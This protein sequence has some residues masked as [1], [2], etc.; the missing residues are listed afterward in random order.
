MALE[1][2]NEGLSSNKLPPIIVCDQLE[3]T[4]GC[5]SRSK[6]SLNLSA[7]YENMGGDHFTIK[8]DLGKHT[9]DIYEQESMSPEDSTDKTL[10]SATYQAEQN[11][12]ILKKACIDIPG[13]NDIM[14]GP[15]FRRAYSVLQHNPPSIKK[16]LAVPERQLRLPGIFCSNQVS[17]TCLR[18]DS[19]TSF[20]KKLPLNNICSNVGVGELSQ[21]QSITSSYR[22]TISQRQPLETFSRGLS[23][24]KNR[25]KSLQDVKGF[26]KLSSL[27]PH[28]SVKKTSQQRSSSGFTGKDLTRGQAEARPS[29]SELSFPSSLELDTL[30]SEKEAS[31]CY[32]DPREGAVIFEETLKKAFNLHPEKDKFSDYLQ[33][34][35]LLDRQAKENQQAMVQTELNLIEALTETKKPYDDVDQHSIRLKKTNSMARILRRNTQAAIA[36]SRFSSAIH[37][38]RLQRQEESPSSATDVSPHMD[39]EEATEDGD[40]LPTIVIHIFCIVWKLFSN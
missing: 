17:P 8:S 9:G 23:A 14:A 18:K 22:P 5:V 35:E 7:S 37:G 12:L 36:S 24:L 30:N 39:V 6:S 28:F 21:R 27:Q 15:Q 20:R 2:K 10:A 40:K 32:Q 38:R 11:K 19:G 26:E 4:M 31:N 13:N 16:R 29:E 3:E 25:A 34:I 33:E 1:P